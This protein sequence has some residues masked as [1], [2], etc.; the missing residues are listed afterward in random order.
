MHH[1]AAIGST[2]VGETRHAVRTV[3]NTKRSGL[4]RFG[5]WDDTAG[6]SEPISPSVEAQKLFRTA[7]FT[8]K[9]Q[10]LF[11]FKTELPLGQMSGERVNFSRPQEW[12]IDD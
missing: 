12:I 3:A 5:E 2:A 7:G 4:S 1:R 9:K 8:C 10:H 6:F 11:E